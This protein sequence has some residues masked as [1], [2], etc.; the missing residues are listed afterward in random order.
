MFHAYR[1]GGSCN[2]LLWVIVTMALSGFGYLVVASMVAR[3]KNTDEDEANPNVDDD[4]RAVCLM[5]ISR[6][7]G[8]E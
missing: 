3:L 7:Q 4:I 1:M 8:S 5:S 6:T 2:T